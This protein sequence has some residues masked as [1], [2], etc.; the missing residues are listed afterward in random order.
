MRWLISLA[1]LLLT[2]AAH[3]GEPGGHYAFRSHGADRGLR[4]QAV[5]VMAQDQAGFIVVGTEDGLYRFDGQSFQALDTAGGLAS[6]SITALLAVADGSLWVGTK[7]GLVAWRGDAPVRGR[8]PLL[9]DQEIVGLARA[10]DGTLL[11]WT[12]T[13]TFLGRPP[14]LRA[15]EGLPG[16]AGSGWIAADGRELVIGRRGTLYRRDRLGRWEKRL[17]PPKYATETPQV[18]LRDGTGRWWVR[19]RAMLLRLDT[20]DGPAHDLS[21]ALPGAAVQKGELYLDAGG[22]LWAPTN[23]GIAFFDGDR[24]GRIDTTRGL[25]NEW[26]TT[27]IRDREG[28]LWIGSE[29]VQQLQGRLRW[30]AHTRQEGLPSDTVWAVARDARG[31]LWAATNRG[32]AYAEEDAWRP[33]AGTADRSFY[34]FARSAAGDFWIGGNSGR[35]RTNRLLHRAPDS[36]RFEAVPLASAAVGV[37]VNSL[38]YGPDGGLYV[39]TLANGLH[40]LRA[41]GNGFQSEQVVLPGGKAD[42]Q[43]NQLARDHRG[44]LWVAGMGGL[45]V[46]DHGRWRRLG[47]RD[48]L[49]ESEVET[50]TPGAGGVWVSYWN[51]K[52]LTRVSLDDDG[53]IHVA[54]IAAPAELIADTI[55]SAGF[56]QQGLWLGTAAG[57]KRWHHGVVERFGRADGLPGDDAAANGFWWDPDGD[58]WFGLSNGLARF[59][60]QLADTGLPLPATVIRSVADG[61]GR[62]LA[63]ARPEVRWDARA[64]TFQFAALSYLDA[65]QLHRQVRLLGFEDAWRDT[66]V[67]EARYTGLLPGTYR[68]QVRARYGSGAYGAVASRSVVVLPPWWLTGWFLAL[69]ALSLVLAIAFAMRWRLARLRR[70]NVELEALVSARTGELRAA[71]AA[72]EQASMVD[73]L[74]GLKNRRFLSV[75]MPGELARVR[76]QQVSPARE[77]RSGDGNNT[78]LCLLMVDL[79]HFKAVNDTHGHPAGD[80]VLRQL[81]DV[82]SR[83]FRESDVVV[84]WGG[85]EFLI[86][87]RN[88]ERGRAAQLAGTICDAIA[89]HAFDIGNGVL[90]HKTCSVGAT[91]FP[92]LQTREAGDGWEAALDLADQCLYAAKRSGR[93]GWVA[94]ITTVSEAADRPERLPDAATLVASGWATLQSSFGGGKAIV[95]K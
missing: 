32:V 31:V 50:V 51:L 12:P 70:R 68:F 57:V 21:P 85:E 13:A 73:P 56:D 71:N 63:A 86:I 8:A 39:G 78:D 22:R 30:S 16:G 43:I 1:A 65:A 5:T 67:G 88:V 81:G 18:I 34:A 20:F 41:H 53:A 90:L 17:L 37:T 7:K 14:A 42:E 61:Q 75:F 23:K 46:L 89:A 64:L 91:A 95:W 76:R 3:A 27:L 83:S 19:G 79:D 92:M 62:L 2:L 49:L 9:V 4:T 36:S 59:D 87:A 69:A 28:S 93:N 66:A 82:L 33:L 24:A 48:G 26:A 58:V 80:A 44:R 47:P 11:V 52:G 74:T 35:E 40:R 45:A 60:A 54:A 55:Y 77:D 84:R 72:L 94:C 15:V 6:A 10:T 25:P 29:G 38:A